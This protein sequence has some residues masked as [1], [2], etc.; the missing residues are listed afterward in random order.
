MHGDL[1]NQ[2]ASLFRQFLGEKQFACSA[3]FFF[4]V[5]STELILRFVSLLSITELF[6]G[7]GKQKFAVKRALPTP[8]M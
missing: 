5:L 7:E 6:D 1:T 3:S 4:F 2:M 8:I